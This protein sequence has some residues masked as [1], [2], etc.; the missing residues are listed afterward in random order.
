MW[1]SPH[2]NTPYLSLG[3]GGSVSLL[4]G[5]KT[6]FKGSMLAGPTEPSWNFRVVGVPCGPEWRRSSRDFFPLAGPGVCILRLASFYS[7]QSWYCENSVG[8]PQRRTLAMTWISSHLTRLLNHFTR[9][10][11]APTRSPRLYSS[12]L[13]FMFLIFVLK[14]NKKNKINNS[15]QARSLYGGRWTGQSPRSPNN[16][17]FEPLGPPQ[18]FWDS[19]FLSNYYLYQLFF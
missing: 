13:D 16:I 7:E 17:R 8:N 6:V 14:K 10:C 18:Q 1:L 4:L 3:K 12:H 9:M 15:D 5:R 19:L 2:L 11:E